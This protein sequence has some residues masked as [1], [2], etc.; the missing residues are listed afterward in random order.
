MMAAAVTAGQRAPSN[1]ISARRGPREAHAAKPRGDKHPD[2]RR[3]MSRADV[4]YELG[5]AEKTLANWRTRGFGPRGFRVGK[6]VR[7]L[8]GEVDRW[9]AEQQAEATVGGEAR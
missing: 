8:R 7:Y 2:E 5:I 3:L 6:A 4:A 9:L 1:G